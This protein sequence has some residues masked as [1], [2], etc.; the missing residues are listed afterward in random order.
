MV[1]VGGSRAVARQWLS[2]LSA[3]QRRSTPVSRLLIYGAGSA[4]VQ[5]ANAIATSHEF[6]LLGFVDDSPSL[7]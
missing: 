4:G 3:G 5:I 2:S 6:K 7:Q 1:M